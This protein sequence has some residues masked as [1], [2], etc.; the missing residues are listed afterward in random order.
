MSIAEKSERAKMLV[1]LQDSFLR[2]TLQEYPK[3][4]FI[5]V[6]AKWM[7]GKE[8]EFSP[9][10]IV[11]SDYTFYGFGGKEVVLELLTKLFEKVVQPISYEEIDE[12]VRGY[13]NCDVYLET[14]HH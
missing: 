11:S 8:V 1:H 13:V 5:E 4:N 9:N 14:G 10:I 6:A 3:L 7:S 12:L 2:I